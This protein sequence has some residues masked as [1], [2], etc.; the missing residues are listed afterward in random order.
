MFLG[1]YDAPIGYVSSL[2]DAFGVGVEGG[3]S[4]DDAVSCASIFSVCCIGVVEDITYGAELCILVVDGLL[5]GVDSFR[6][7][8][9]AFF[10]FGAAVGSKSDGEALVAVPFSVFF[11]EVEELLLVFVDVECLSVAACEELCCSLFC[12]CFLC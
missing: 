2:L 5:D 4:D 11:E 7:C 1:E 3:C 8:F 6:C 10:L 12:F 9:V